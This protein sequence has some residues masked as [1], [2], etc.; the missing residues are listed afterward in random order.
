MARWR[1]DIIRK[2]L[3][4]LYTLEVPHEKSA[5]EKAGH[6]IQHPT[7]TTEQDRGY[8]ARI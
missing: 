6:D 8:A 7:G 5:I 3:A 1:V 2:V 4:T